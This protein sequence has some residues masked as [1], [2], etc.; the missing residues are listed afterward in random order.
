MTA[1]SRIVLAAAALALVTAGAAGAAAAQPPAPAQPSGAMQGFQVNRDQPVKIESNSLEV[2]DKSRQATFLGDVKLTQG[3]T[4]ITCKTLVVFYDDTPPAASKT[5]KKG[6]PV[7]QKAGPAPGG[8]Q[9]SRVEAKGDVMV[10]QKDQTAKGDNATF[11]VKT[12]TVRLIGNV[13][14]TQGTNVLRGERMTVNLTTGITMVESSKDN[15]TRR[16]EGMFTPSSPPKDQKGA[17]PA[18]PQ[19]A[20]PPTAK[21]GAPIRIN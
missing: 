9:I 16:V 11:D 4:T 17:P 15:K 18:P 14:V 20:P 10:M 19:H 7:A 12:N 8:Q 1:C 2:R 5:A 13:V 3:D 21:S 6:T